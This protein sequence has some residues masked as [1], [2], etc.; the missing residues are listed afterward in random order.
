MFWHNHYW[1]EP[2]IL[3]WVFLPGFWHITWQKPTHAQHHQ[4]RSPWASYCGGNE[5]NG[6]DRELKA[7]LNQRPTSFLRGKNRDGMRIASYLTTNWNSAMIEM[8]NAYCYS[9]TTYDCNRILLT[10]RMNY[11]SSVLQREGL[12]NVE[13]VSSWMM[14]V[15]SWIWTC[16]TI[17]TFAAI[18]WRKI[19]C[20]SIFKMTYLPTRLFACWDSPKPWP[21]IWPVRSSCTFKGW[22]QKVPANV[23]CFCRKKLK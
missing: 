23:D 7:T 5:I 13:P 3:F 10:P 11:C 4:M 19:G 6:A 16:T 2:W 22:Q 9:L 15:V 14:S 12:V 17:H 1:I 21:L 20:I 8:R 18:F